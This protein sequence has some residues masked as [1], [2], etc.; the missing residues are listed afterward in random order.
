MKNTKTFHESQAQSAGDANSEVSKVAVTAFSVI[1][2]SI[3]IWAV[4]SVIAGFSQSGGP[5]SL[6]KSL[7]TAITGN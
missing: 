2:A 6:I 3:G 5:L 4:A 7:F 1:S